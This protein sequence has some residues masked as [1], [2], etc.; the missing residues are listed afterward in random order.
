VLLIKQIDADDSILIA[1]RHCRPYFLLQPGT[2]RPDSKPIVPVD[3]RA[4]LHITKPIRF[5]EVLN[6]FLI[7]VFHILAAKGFALS[8]VAEIDCDGL[9]GQALPRGLGRKIMIALGHAAHQ[10]LQPRARLH[11]WYECDGGV[12]NP[13]PFL[14]SLVLQG[15]RGVRQCAIKASLDIF[16]LLS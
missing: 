13:V 5:V 16:A 2:R 1:H 11:P 15:C 4:H 8:A 10:R 14:K 9:N 12:C 6:V 7:N 3:D